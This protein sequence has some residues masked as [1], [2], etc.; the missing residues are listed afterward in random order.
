MKER[1]QRAVL[2]RFGTF[3]LDFASSELRKG[4]ALVKLQSQHFQLLALLAERAGQ[5]VSREEIRRALWDNETFVDFD[6]SINFAVNQIRGALDDDPHS[7]RY[8]ETLPRKGYRFVA[9]VTEAG[10]ERAELEPSAE[11][12]VVSKSVST[13]RWWLLSAGVLVAL[14]AIALAAK[15]VISRPAGT[16]PIESLAVLPLENLSHDPEQDYFADGMTEELITALAKI[17]A[18]RVISR[19]SV[20]QYKGTKKP[21]PQIARELNVDAVLEGTVTQDRG[22]VRITTQLIR[23]A[24]EQHLWAEK[25]EGSLSEV[26][27]VQDAVAKAVVRGIQIKVTPRERTLLAKRSTQ[28][29]EAHQLYLKGR[30]YWN[31]RTEPALKRAIE[32]FQQA[33]DKD[34]GYSLAYAGLTDCYAVYATYRVESPQ[35]AGPKAKAAATRALEIDDTLANAHASFGMIKMQYDWDWTGAERELRRSIELDPNYA[36]AH[37]W[38]SNCLAATGRTEQAIASCRRALQLEP[39]S[40]IIN[41]DLGFFLFVA[42]RYDEAI[43]HMLDALE[44]DPSF[45]QGHW[46]L[47]LPYEQKAMYQKA[48]VEFQKVFELSGPT[49]RTLGCIGHAYG[50]SGN[51]EKALQTLADLRELSKRHFISASDIAMIYLGLG[52]REHALQWLEK[53]FEDRPWGMVFMKVDPR[54]DGLR[55]DSRFANLLRRMKL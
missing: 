32:Y 9:P 29:A 48:S 46:S 11:A 41:G 40:M 53:G 52:D 39:L 22:R 24:P 17:S 51:R 50:L 21:I 8:I 42:R 49:S 55:A 44:I 31:R 47:G 2:L 6:R 26:L 28:N 12:G 54:F 45:A 35:V 18:L 33:I 5:V 34:P 3:E 7:P 37:Q 36:T 16:K 20:M 4:G 15:M 19:T 38:L 10:D 25:Y 27:T 30:Y 43:E 14:V 23:A 13:R 1:V